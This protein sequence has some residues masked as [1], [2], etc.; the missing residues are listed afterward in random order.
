M[1][2]KKKSEVVVET[3]ETVE[4]SAEQAAPVSE[5]M[6]TPVVRCAFKEMVPV[7]HLTPHPMNPNEHP[8]L[9]LDTFVTI[10]MATGWRRPITV[11]KRSGWVT[12]G[13]GALQAATLA[14][15]S[16]APVDFQDYDSEEQEL[17][18]IAADNQLAKMAQ[19]NTGKLQKLLVQINNGEFNMELTGFKMPQ[20]EKL[21][22]VSNAPQP[23]FSA[24]GPVDT[25]SGFEPGKAVG[26]HGRMPDHMTEGAP[27]PASHVRMVQLFFNDQTQKEF[28]DIVDYFE[29]EL[30]IDNVTDTVLEVMRSAYRNHRNAEHENSEANPPDLA[31]AQGAMA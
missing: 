12:K 3:P 6:N 10:I 7:S 21:L 8:P 20:L 2:K 22:A 9:Q 17:A 13:H 16:H 15:W 24:P 14:G 28:M 1:A 18:D 19:L 4:A 25:V 5:A 30:S 31:T 23:E 11:S 26:D 27:A 29:K